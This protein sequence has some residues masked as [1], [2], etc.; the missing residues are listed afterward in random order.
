MWYDGFQRGKVRG[1]TRYIIPAWKKD[2]H[3]RHKPSGISGRLE[4]M[5]TAGG[6]LWKMRLDK[7]EPA[8][9]E[10]PWPARVVLVHAGDLEVVD[11]PG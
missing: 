8:T 2:D 9:R 1:Q 7:P 10:R 11:V 4:V 5:E 3:V 6:E